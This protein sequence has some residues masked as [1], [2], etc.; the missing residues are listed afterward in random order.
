[1]GVVYKAEDL[2]LGR[3]VALKFLPEELATDDS[4]LRRFESEARAA[5]ALNHPNIC[6]IYEVEEHEKQ[7]FIVMELLEGQTLRDSIA[8]TALGRPGMELAKLLDLAVQ[9]TAGLEAAHHQGIIH[10]DIKPANIFV[11]S[12]GQAKILD[13]GLAKLFLTE[14]A[15]ASSPSPDHRDGGNLCDP[16]R[17]PGSLTVSSP[18][19]SR[20]GVAMGTAGYMSPEQVRGEKLDARTDLFSLGLVLYEMAAG[21]RAFAGETTPTLHDAI[22]NHTPTPVR[23]LNPV[24]PLN[25]EEIIKKG[26]EKERELRYQ[27]ASEIRADLESVRRKPQPTLLGTRWRKMGAVVA[28]LFI[29]SAIFL[30]PKRQPSSQFVPDLKLRQLTSN[31]A[32]NPVTS[33]AISP[34][35][36]YLAYADTKRMYIKLIETGEVQTVP[37]PVALAGKNVGWEIVPGWFP[38]GTGFLANAHPSGQATDDWSSQGTSIWKASVLGGPPHKLRDEAYGY[39]ISP[40]GSAIAFGANKGRVG[41]REIWLMGP[42]G[43][44]AN[45]LYDTSEESPIVWMSWSP[46]GR[47]VIY[48]QTGRSGD[49]MAS[50]DLHG[51]T[52]TTLLQDSELKNMHELSW[53]PDGRI[54]YAMDEPGAIGNTCNF[55][56]MRLDLHTGEAIEKPKRVTNW[57]GFCMAGMSATADGKRLAFLGWARHLSSYVADLGG[58]GTRILNM[59]QFPL[60]E[61]SDGASDW[62]ADS[63]AVILLSD[64]SGRDEIYTQLLGQDKADLLVSDAARNARV[65]ADG[66]WVLYFRH[67]SVAPPVPEPVMRVPIAGGPSQFL[68]TA[69]AHSL[70]LCARSPSDLCAIAEPSEDRTQ[71]VVTTLD[72]LKGRGAELMRFALDPNEDCWSIELSPD[73]TRIAATRSPTGPVYILSLRGEADQQVRVRNWSN[74]RYV[75][76][77]TDGK[78][79]FVTAGVPSGRVL[80]HV[81][82]QGNAHALWKNAG[83]SGETMARPSPDGRH[84]ALSG[85]TTN[86]NMWMMENF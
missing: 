77:T 6:T 82:L 79:L 46:D 74:L 52:P 72:P 81:D 28:A 63:K 32:D 84:L 10:R 45:K 8:S 66:K 24:L 47:R 65:S 25:L 67:K 36:K 30:A 20:S 78:G 34:D 22:L 68:F 15:A 44:R 19:H 12:E 21:Q 27:T 54:I 83:G 39:S 60:R 59:Q 50:R 37:E 38:D 69:R 49:T 76:W 70:I 57:S 55:W 62:A 3:R 18:F 58:D 75:G 64:R 48:I 42:N 26:L 35:G 13:F 85:W 1:M 23:K 31:S 14:A 33:G 4:A 41:E 71:L 16:R 7:P 2:R 5:S 53:T 43:E 11:T 29:A 61:S 40:D 9:I 56:V 17:E 86:G 73:G 51:G 80:L